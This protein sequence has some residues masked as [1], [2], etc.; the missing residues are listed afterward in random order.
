M[1]WQKTNFTCIRQSSK[2]RTYIEIFAQIKR[3]VFQVYKR[4]WHIHIFIILPYYPRI[5]NRSRFH[6]LNRFSDINAHPCARIYY[7]EHPFDVLSSVCHVSYPSIYTFQFSFA[8]FQVPIVRFRTVVVC[9]SQHVT[10]AGNNT[11][12]IALELCSKTCFGLL[13]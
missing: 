8:I 3:W 6:R 9:V 5:K 7:I 1:F 2:S 11:Y 10:A 13:F 12:H 4:N